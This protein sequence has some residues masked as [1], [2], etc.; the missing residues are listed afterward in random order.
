[1]PFVV[2][3]SEVMVND[4]SKDGLTGLDI[5]TQ[6]ETAVAA[7]GD[8]VVV[9]YNNSRNFSGARSV[10]GY[11]RSSDG[12]ASFNDLGLMPP[13]AGPPPGFNFGDPGLVADG[14]GNFYASAIVFDVTRPSGFMS[15]VGVSKSTDG[16]LTFNAPVSPV[17]SGSPGTFHFADKE[18]IAVDTT[19][20]PFD[21][22]VY[23]SWTDFQFN[24]RTGFEAPITFSRST[25]GGTSFSAP[26]RVS[27]G[28]PSEIVQGSEPA[29]GPNGEVY[30]AWFRWSPVPSGVFIAKST[31]GGGSFGPPIPVAS[32]KWIGFGVP[33]QFLPSL[34]G[35]FRVNSFPRIDVDPVN[36]NV[37][38]TFAANGSGAGGDGADVFFTRSTD[39]GATWSVPVRVN[40]DGTKNDQFFPDIAVNQDGVIEAMWYDRRLDASNLKIDVFRAQSMD[41]GLSFGPNE[42]VTAQSFLP[43][44]G[45]DPIISRVY[46]SS[47]LG[48]TV[49]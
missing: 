36:G 5:T 33:L 6:S 34:S 31:N 15:P 41:G 26:I 17:P 4:P 45:Y 30:V 42:R 37:Y 12:G 22:D 11:S 46:I 8:N 35:N 1:M 24:P 9:A 49:E 19:G 47:W 20:G 38:I 44:V 40:D 32:L 21:G 18:F 43:A 39:G 23:L 27:F 25:D 10:M 28:G 48:V 29:V 7:F 2:S 16:G 3:P 13:P 14:Q